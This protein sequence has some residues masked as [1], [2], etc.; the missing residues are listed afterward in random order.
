[1]TKVEYFD[2]VFDILDTFDYPN[3]I[4]TYNEYDVANTISRTIH[5]SRLA[6]ISPMMCAILV[7]SLTLNCQIMPSVKGKV[8]H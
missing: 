2:K 3:M 7:W 6:G 5:T 1:M 8:I 4:A